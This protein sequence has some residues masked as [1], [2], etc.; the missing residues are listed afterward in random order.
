MNSG[1]W[2]LFSGFFP[3]LLRFYYFLSISTKHNPIPTYINIH[4]L[5]VF[6]HFDVFFFYSAKQNILLNSMEYSFW[7]C[8]VEN[9]SEVNLFSGSLQDIFSLLSLH[10]LPFIVRNFLFLTSCLT[11]THTHPYLLFII[12][13]LIFMLCWRLELDFC[14]GFV[15]LELVKAVFG[16][17]G[18]GEDSDEENREPHKQANHFLQ[19][20]KWD[21]E[22]GIWALRSLWCRGCP[23]RLLS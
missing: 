12:Y 6:T 16:R 9:K 8:G 17:D 13:S 18:E 4:I 23:N 14:S 3:I 1:F 7:C 21:Y 5:Y 10:T 19:T 15:F 20:E 11:H 2:S 22:K